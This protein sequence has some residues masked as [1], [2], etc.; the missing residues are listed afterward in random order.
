MRVGRVALGD[1]SIK[2]IEMLINIWNDHDCAVLYNWQIPVMTIIEM[3]KEANVYKC[4]IQRNFW[5][6]E[7]G[8]VISNIEI[9]LYDKNDD[10]VPQYLPDFIYNAF[11]ANYT[12]EEAVILYSSGTTGRSKG[13]ILSHY[14]IN[15][16]ADAI[17]DYMNLQ[18]EDCIYLVK[19]LSHASTLTGELLVALKTHIKLLIAPII[20]PPRYVLSNINKFHVTIIGLNPTLL[21]FLLDAFQHFGYNLT[22]L[23]IIYVS[24]EILNDKIYLQAY[25]TLH[26]IAIYNVYGLTEAGPRV[27]AQRHGCCKSNSVGKPIKGVDV[28]VITEQGKI[29]TI[30]E[31]GIVHIKTPSLYSGYITSSVERKSLYQDWYNTGDLGFIDHNNELHISGRI[32]DMIIFESHKIYP[33]EIEALIIESLPVSECVILKVEF[34]DKEIIGCLYNTNQDINIDIRS[35]LKKR[36]PS[37]EIPRIYIRCKKLPYSTNGKLLRS[38]A[39]KILIKAMEEKYE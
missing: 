31:E 32:D 15:T 25:K 30:G 33:C 12:K 38:E 22:S 7:Y 34:K 13:I 1:N 35:E 5:K 11:N 3:M 28:L 14:A 18:E 10:N 9:V 17:I 19:T 16:N 4:V 26:N 27:T 24:G 37:Y 6:E 20:V 2:Y 21:I 23:R 36:L 8:Q 29:A 39:K